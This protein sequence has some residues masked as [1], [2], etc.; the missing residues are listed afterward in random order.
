LEHFDVLSSAAQPAAA[1]PNAALNP[2]VAP[3]KGKVYGKSSARWSAARW[4][5]AFK[6]P[7]SVDPTGEH[8]DE[9]QS[10]DGKVW[11]PAGAITPGATARKCTVPAGPV[12]SSRRE[13]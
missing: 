7:G 13:W 5:W 6:V 12:F 10:I 3:L 8:C 9:G 11:F 4:Q 2:G 1:E